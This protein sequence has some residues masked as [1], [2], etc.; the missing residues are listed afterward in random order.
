MALAL[1]TPAFA[2]ATF[3]ESCLSTTGF[4]HGLDPYGR[5]NLSVRAALFA[6]AGPAYEIDELFSGDTVCV[7]TRN[8]RPAH[9]R[10]FILARAVLTWL[11]PEP[12]A[13][14]G[15]QSPLSGNLSLH[16]SKTPQSQRRNAALRSATKDY[17]YGHYEGRPH[18]RAPR[19]GTAAFRAGAPSSRDHATRESEEALA[20]RRHF[21]IDLVPAP[22]TS[23]RAGGDGSGGGLKASRPRPPRLSAFTLA[24]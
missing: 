3:P 20:R 19:E 1:S 9:K 4:V 16:I 14:R 10:H 12:F 24:C 2:A 23:A 22:Q 7:T 6:P 11:S 8:R 15:A 13:N 21:K 5:N 17:A 18:R